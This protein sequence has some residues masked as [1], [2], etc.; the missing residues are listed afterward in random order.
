M[1][2]FLEYRL[3][4]S[5]LPFDRQLP[6]NRHQ[7]DLGLLYLYHQR[8]CMI[9]GHNRLSADPSWGSFADLC[10]HRDADQLH[11][12][13]MPLSDLEHLPAQPTDDSRMHVSPW[14]KP[15]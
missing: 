3:Y 2:G 14:T 4:K 11:A 8:I 9:S 6:M 10:D 5:W 15:V 13:V 7:T 12:P 1:T